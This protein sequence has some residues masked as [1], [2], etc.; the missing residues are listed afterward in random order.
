[1]KP[2]G[3]DGGDIPARAGVESRSQ[4]YLTDWMRARIGTIVAE[5]QEVQGSIV[6]GH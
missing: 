3:F 2:V 4:L 5:A 1:V 6:F